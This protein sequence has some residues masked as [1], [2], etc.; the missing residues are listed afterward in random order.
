MREK[1]NGKSV[2]AILIKN[3]GCISTSKALETLAKIFEK[4]KE[5]RSSGRRE[6]WRKKA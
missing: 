6:K 1:N 5:K 2:F 3:I 4:S